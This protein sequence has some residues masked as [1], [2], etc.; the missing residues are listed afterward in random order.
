MPP[1]KGQLISIA[2]KGLLNSPE[3]RTKCTQDMDPECIPSNRKTKQ[4]FENYF[5]DVTVSDCVL[6][7]N[8][9]YSA[10]CKSLDL[11]MPICQ[12]L[13]ID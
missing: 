5:E 11:L 7:S 8:C 1:T 12:S 9:N 6:F 3:K 10:F 4:G 2:I 13:N